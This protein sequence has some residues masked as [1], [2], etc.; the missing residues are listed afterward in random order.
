MDAYFE[1]GPAFGS[2]AHPS[3]QLTL[4][5]LAECAAGLDARSRILDFGCGS[6]ILLLAA[7]RLPHALLV[8]VDRLPVAVETTRRNLSRSGVAATVLRGDRPDHASIAR[9]GPFDL[10]LAN[11]LAELHIPLLQGYARILAPG[12]EIVLSGILRWQTGDVEAAAEACGLR[13]RGRFELDDWAALV[14][15]PHVE[16]ADAQVHVAGEQG[17][18]RGE[19]EQ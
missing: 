13:T 7:S 19:P 18:Q 5:A 11:L 6:G 3:T 15:A 1:A 4:A 14:L 16:E 10:V 2:G 12:G 9:L 8:G 17:E